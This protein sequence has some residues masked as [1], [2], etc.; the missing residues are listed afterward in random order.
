ML[1]GEVVAS[2]AEV[3][4]VCGFSG[5]TVGDRLCCCSRS[6][7]ITP[8]FNLSSEALGSQRSLSAALATGATERISLGTL[9]VE[10]STLGCAS[11]P[12]DGGSGVSPSF[13]LT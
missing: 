7:L 11:S 1:V 5:V 6:R 10:N 3:V 8:V 12:L 13:C 2:P 4:D 9:V